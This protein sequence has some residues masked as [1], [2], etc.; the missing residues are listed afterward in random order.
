MGS[1]AAKVEPGDNGQGWGV[2]GTPLANG[3]LKD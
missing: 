3:G 1:H 2:D